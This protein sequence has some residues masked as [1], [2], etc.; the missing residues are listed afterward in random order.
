MPQ[1]IQAH[2]NSQCTRDH[3]GTPV[4]R[5]FCLD[6]ITC[7]CGGVAIRAVLRVHDGL[8]DEESY[9]AYVTEFVGAADVGDE[10]R[11]FFIPE[12]VTFARSNV[13][14]LEQRAPRR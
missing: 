4:D 2:V 1:H 6:E 13:I 3:A 8:A 5:S 11:G 14:H 12:R 9:G 10:Y 7:C